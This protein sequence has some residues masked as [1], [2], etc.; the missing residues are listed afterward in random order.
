VLSRQGDRF[1]LKAQQASLRD[2]VKALGTMLAI[3]VVAR[4]HQ[5]TTITLDFEG[6]SLQDTL[7]R[8]RTFANIISLTET[9]QPASKIIKMIVLPIQGVQSV[10]RPMVSSGA[11]PPPSP[12]V[13]PQPFTF[14][15]DP[16]THREGQQ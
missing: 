7:Q 3:E 13:S 12:W 9:T 10:P 4:I 6:L 8:L 16:S 5:A 15:F 14:E 1:S 11:T 2:I